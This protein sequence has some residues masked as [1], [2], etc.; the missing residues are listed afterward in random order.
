MS[1]EVEGVLSRTFEVGDLILGAD[2]L[3]MA[4]A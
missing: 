1:C 4:A 2:F 3:G